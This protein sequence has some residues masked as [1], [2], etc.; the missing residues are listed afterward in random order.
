MDGM[1]VQ[2]PSTVPF[3]AS[4]QV[5]IP[6]FSMTSSPSLHAFM[7]RLMSHNEQLRCL[8]FTDIETTKPS[9]FTDLSVPVFNRFTNLICVTFSLE[10]ADGVALVPFDEELRIVTLHKLTNVHLTLHGYEEPEIW[11]SNCYLNPGLSTHR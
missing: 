4:R 10:Q 2:I 7:S 3:A 5:D 6:I 11:V 9:L 1:T 8:H